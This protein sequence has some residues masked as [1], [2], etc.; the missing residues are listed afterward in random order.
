MNKKNYILKEIGVL[1]VV[2]VMIL[3]TVVVTAN[4]V[5]DINIRNRQ[6]CI[7]DSFEELGYT[8]IKSD[9]NSYLQNSYGP[10]LFNQLPIPDDSSGLGPF[11][12]VGYY[13]TYDN[14]WGLTEDIHDVHWWGLWYGGSG[15][16]TL[17]DEFEISFCTDNGGI[18]D[19]NNHIVDFTGSLGDEITYV[20][21]GKSYWGW[22]A[23][24]MEMDLPSPVSMPSG[25]I[26]FYKT[27]DN[28][29]TFA[30]LDAET[31]DG[32]SYRTIYGL[33][34]IDCSFQLI[35]EELTKLE[36]ENVAGGLGFSAEIVNVGPITAENVN[37][38]LRF[39][40]GMIISPTN[41]IVTGGP[42]SIP[43]L[44]NL[45]IST[46]AFGFGGF[47]LPLNIVITATADNALPVNMTYPVKLFLIFVSI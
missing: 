13:R 31:G 14:F 18:P 3:S 23:Y 9:S 20:D 1:L 45:P 2:A 42:L 32:K 47:I 33:M 41:G 44:G 12:D 39:E 6:I 36:I 46:S 4:K 29:Q 27:N 19:Y 11:S 28:S 37:W 17:G 25:W 40:G 21:T 30:W 10:V 26:S 35:G 8:L 24:Y 7:E 16:P 34:S 38:E 5:D 15:I 22:E 43:A